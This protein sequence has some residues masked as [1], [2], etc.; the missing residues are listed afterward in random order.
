MSKGKGNV[1]RPEGSVE[2]LIRSLSGEPRGVSTGQVV[3]ATG[4]SRQA[5]HYHLSRMVRRGELVR[6]GAGRGTRYVRHVDLEHVYVLV[7]LQED[8][9]WREIAGSVPGLSGAKANV[10]SILAHSFTEMLNNAIDHSRGT[11]VRVAVQA[12]ADVIGF[13]VV[14]DGV[15]VF[16]NVREK[17]G[18]PDDFASIQEIAK[19]KATTAPEHHTGEGIF[20]TS[21]MVDRFELESGVLRWTVDNLRRDQ[22][23]G[24]VPVRTGTRVACAIARDSARTTS[25]VFEAYAGSDSFSF[26]ESA[27]AVGLF[28]TG[29]TFVSRSEA[30]RLVD[31]LERFEEVRLDF[32]GVEQVG[33]GFVDEIFRVWASDHPQTRLIPIN[34]SPAVEPMVTRSLG[35][36]PGSA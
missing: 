9:V 23:V 17:L 10:R 13:E 27:I 12:R 30:K 6:Q 33:Q 28:E 7:G 3:S 21:K 18:L 16:K 5:V 19:G 11:A 15:G 24:D 22:A 26:S 36:P 1:D 4:L 8:L 25:E 32:G 2:A 20:F 35:E 31:R 14:D 34:M 29:G